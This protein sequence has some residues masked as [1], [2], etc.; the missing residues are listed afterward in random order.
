ME[1]TGPLWW[2]QMSYTVYIMAG[3]DPGVEDGTFIHHHCHHT[4][5]L[6]ATLLLLLASQML[7]SFK[8]WE[9]SQARPF[10]LS[11][12]P[13]D[14]ILLWAV[15]GGGLPAAQH[16]ALQ[17]RLAL[18]DEVDLAKDGAAQQDVDPWVQDLVPGGQPHA[19]H[20]QGLIGGQIIPNRVSVGV[21]HWHQ[22]KDLYTRQHK[23]CELLD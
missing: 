19:H 11:S 20:Q 3:L 21:Y 9:A 18:G 12:D 15:E 10:S 6:C 8:V 23:H 14:C 16:T 4:P 17:V 7:K 2:S 22:A 5:P 1:E 13:V